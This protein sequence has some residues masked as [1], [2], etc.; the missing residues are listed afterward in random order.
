[1]SKPQ[2]ACPHCHCEV[3]SDRWQRDGKLYCCQACQQGHPRG[4]SQCQ[5]AGCDCGA[6]LAA[7]GAQGA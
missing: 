5:H 4:M 2:C 3:D 1:M 6:R 7:E